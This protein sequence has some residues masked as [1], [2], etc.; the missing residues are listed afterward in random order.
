MKLITLSLSFLLISL[1]SFSQETTKIKEV[2][3]NF[4]NFDNYGLFYKTGSDTKLWRF[5]I[6]GGGLRITNVNRSL[7]SSSIS[8]QLNFSVGREKRREFAPNLDFVSGI[9]LLSNFYYFESNGAN[10]N[11]SLQFG[12]G[13]GGVFGLRYEINKTFFGGAEVL[14]NLMYYSRNVSNISAFEIDL[15]FSTRAL[16]TFGIQF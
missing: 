12:A 13:I 10:P 15:R 4:Y 11:S 8:G 3:L 1:S 7:P 6:L 2:G 16:L 14:P 9:E 5:R